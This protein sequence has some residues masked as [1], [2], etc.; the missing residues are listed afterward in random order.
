MRGDHSPGPG[1]LRA[2]SCF[3]VKE[4]SGILLCLGNFGLLLLLLL[5][6]T[7]RPA[8]T[9]RPSLVRV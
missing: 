5:L 3:P 8:L 1:L 4:N 7:L 2:L 9:L 6:M